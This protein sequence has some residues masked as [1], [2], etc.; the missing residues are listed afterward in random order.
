MAS[1]P[2]SA[3]ATPVRP[4]FGTLLVDHMAIA[5]YRDG[6]W[7]DMRLQ[8]TGPLELSPAAHV[9]HYA[10]S[11]FEGF[12]AYRW[13]D[14]SVNLF[15]MDRH[16]A[17]LRQSAKSLALPPPDARQLADMVRTLITRCGDQ[18]PE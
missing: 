8:A 9:L 4:A 16:I 5:S 11:C 12:K 15:R 18:V 14:G 2:K 1:N 13:A 17:R 7:S 10:S 3:T 6:R